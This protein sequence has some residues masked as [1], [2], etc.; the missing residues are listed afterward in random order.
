MTEINY[1]GLYNTSLQLIQEQLQEAEELRY[2]ELA[3]DHIDS[4][5]LNTECPAAVLLIGEKTGNPIKLAQRIHALDKFLS[6][7]IIND[8]QNHQQIKQALLFT[9]FIGN[10][11]QCV[12]NKLGK[13]LATT[14]QDAIA[15]THQRRNYARLQSS[16]EIMRPN[17]HLYK[18]VQTEY[19]DKFLQEAPIG[20]LLL[21]KEG[22]VMAIN[23]HA[24][25]VLQTTEK[26]I[27]GKPLASLFP[28]SAQLELSSFIQQTPAGTSIRI[29]QRIQQEQAQH[30]ELRLAEI[31][32]KNSIQYK[33]GILADITGK[34]LNQQKIEQQLQAL[35]QANRRLQRANTDLDTFVYT[36]SHDL[37]APIANIEGLIGLLKRK[38]DAT[39]SETALVFNMIQTSIQRFQTT[40]KDLTEVTHL[41]KEAE[42]EVL[43][44]VQE[45][46]EEVQTLLH[47][48]IVSTGA[49]IEADF[50]EC[51]EIHFSRSN[52]RSIIY[53]LLSNAIKYRSPRRSPHI[54]IKLEQVGHF[55]LLTVQDNGLGISPDKKDKIF[56]MFKRLH[57]HVEG[58]GVGLFI[59]KRIV[60]NAEGSIEVEA[61]EGKGATFKIYLKQTCA[62]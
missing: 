20:A 11:L 8:I 17:T 7:V 45:V 29:F 40:I 53:N 27:L 6:I 37:K 9:P 61:E 41:Q 55:N 36:A 1:T 57:S 28:A 10:T 50:R 23:R 24:T 49:T 32:L 21:N 25:Q 30:L 22:L 60:D 51:S 59:V 62:S 58:T 33:I 26:E 44:N 12:P 43:I 54:L 19:L 46:T 39:D 3:E 4:Y 56:T 31:P 34:V 13:G 5:L 16:P 42:E 47:E 35:E 52:F 14:V 38:T 15:R 2:A 48:M 18:D